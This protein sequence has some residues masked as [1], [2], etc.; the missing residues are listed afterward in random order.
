MEHFKISKLLNDSTISKFVLIKWVE[1][2]DL[3]GGHYSV[4]KNIRFKTPML[5]SYFCDYSDAYIVV[6]GRINIRAVANTDINQKD[7]LFKNNA[8]FISCITKI[9]NTLIDNMEDL[10]IV[11][12]RYNLLE[13]SHNYSMTSG[14]LWN[15]Y[16][17][18]ID[19]V[20]DNASNSKLFEYMTKAIGKTAARR[21]RPAQPSQNPDTVQPP[22]PQ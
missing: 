5:R 7:A 2:N 19:V 8:P 3:S 21:P 17:D 1:R 11:M 4:I 20:D 10:D 18:G 15:Y 12:P 16:K 6:K 14:N 9:N 22:Q 13:D